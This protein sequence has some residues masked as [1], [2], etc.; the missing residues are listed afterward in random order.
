MKKP[1]LPLLVMGALLVGALLFLLVR[2]N[3]EP[4]YHGKRLSTWLEILR[5][6]P[7]SAARG[8]AEEA[9]RAIGT[10]ALPTLIQRIRAG[11]ELSLAEKLNELLGKQSLVKFHFTEHDNHGEALSGFE[12]L[13]PIGRPAVP[14]LTRLI[15]TTN[16]SGVAAHALAY[17]GP[18]ALPVLCRGLTN[19]DPT[20]QKA[21]AGALQWADFDVAAAIPSL[22]IQLKHQ[23]RGVR[24]VSA[25]VLGHIAQQPESVI[26]A[27][28]EC[29]TD[30]DRV[31]RSEAAWSIGRFGASN[32]LPALERLA[33]DLNQD[34][35]TREA[36]A[37]LKKI[38][39]PPSAAPPP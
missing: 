9:V 24:W 27:L 1:N 32:A 39:P 17:V 31:V 6:P 22:L 2:P 19:Q 35:D 7:T 21:C 11:N 3:N 26:P 25:Y 30:S 8:E 33:S 20:I 5:K 18:E 29:L 15:E 13:G 14:E 16:C 34:S 28:I 10:D 37:A 4:S 23:N 38:K 36:A 12:A